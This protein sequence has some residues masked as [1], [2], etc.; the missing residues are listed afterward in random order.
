MR[1]TRAG[2]VGLLLLLAA[3]L[4]ASPLSAQSTSSTVKGVVVDKDGQPLP[5]VT[6]TLENPSLGVTGLGGV[7]NP[8]GEFRITPVPPGRGYT[9]RASLPAYQ[10][11]EFKDLEIPAGKTLVQNI[12]LRPAL[13]ERIRVQ[14]KEEV[15]NTETTTISTTI[16]SEFISGLPVLGRDY[17]D[18][19]TLAPGVTD[20]NDTGNPNIHGARDTSVVTLVDGVNT[21]DPFTGQYGQELNIESI[22]EIEVI[23][24]GASAEYGRA[25]GGFIRIV[26]K[27]GGNEFEGSFRFFLRT[28]ALD[29]DGAGIDPSELRGGLGET[30]GLRDLRFTDLQPFLALGGAFIK[31]KWWYYFTPQYDQLEQPVNA[32]TQSFVRRLTSLRALAKSTWQVTSNNKL[33]LSINY[34]DTSIYDNGLNSIIARESG[35]TS[36][37]GGPTITLT[38]TAILSP[39]LS[40]ETTLS[41]FDQNHRITPTTDPDTNGNG[42]LNVDKRP[43]LGGN[44]NGFIELRERDPGVDWDA[45]GRFDIFEDFNRNGSLDGCYTDPVTAEKICYPDPR[46]NFRGE[47][48]DRDGRLTLGF[49]CEG[50]DRED[51]D[52]DG[53][54]D[55]EIDLDGNGVADPDEDVGIPCN[56]PQACPQGYVP[57]TRGNGTLDSEDRD[58]NLILS[59]L[60]GS[61][62]S[63]FPFWNDRN[64][65]GVP[66]IGEFTSPI[67]PDRQYLFSFNTNRLTGPYRITDNDYRTRNT[68]REDVNWYIDDLFGSHDLKAGLVLENE[69]YDADLTRRPLWQVSTGVDLETGRIGGTIDAFLPTVENATNE[70]GS[71]NLALFFHDTYKPL[72]NLTIGLGLR[73][74]REEVR[75]DGFTFFEPAAERARFDLLG[76]LGGIESKEDDLNRD[77]I[78]TR[79]LASDPLYFSNNPVDPSRVASLNGD[80]LAIAPARLTRHNFQSAID[81]TNFGTIGLTDP[82]LLKNGFPR[83]PEEIAIT[84]NNLAPRLSVAWDPWAD[85]KTKFTSSWGRYYDKLF[86]RTVI[87]EAGP[88]FLNPYY[89]YDGDGVDFFGLPN[90]KVGR[91]ISSAP[92]SAN[93]VD[94]NLRTPFTDEF[95]F[96]FTRE[97]APEVSISFNYID[98][99]FRDLLQDVDMN[100]SPRRPTATLS[101]NTTL[102]GFC[103][104]FGITRVRPPGGGGGEAGKKGP[105]ER[106]P[107]RYPDLYINNPNFNQVLRVGNFNYQEYYAY[108]LQFVRRLSRKWQMDASYVFSKAQGQAEDFLSESGDDPAVAELK[109]GFLDYDQRHVA[110]FNAHVFLPGDWRLGTRLTWASGTPYSFVQRFR[111]S[112]NLDFPQTRRLYGTTDENSGLFIDENRNIHRNHA[113]Y[114]I[115]VRAEK[116]FV[117]GRI[118]ASAFLD[119]ENLLNQDRLRVFEIQDNFDFLQSVEERDFG[120]RFQVGITM[121]F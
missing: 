72:S 9:L 28:Q 53:R 80:L 47:D 89:G 77:G 115:S 36:S 68:F 88:D 65:N 69:G 13:T 51:I 4:L 23:T 8:Q 78:I 108:E 84:N 48:L 37:R 22:E 66:E 7:T 63:A 71:D 21:T 61:D 94:R 29:H 118:S 83:Q 15:V 121:N 1:S 44:R 62:S 27:S 109:A 45:D 57:G 12:T 103:D 120:R 39:S 25:Q 14:G 73:F 20:V 87:G 2:R 79:S 64:G 90:N 106:I 85:G 105:D 97:I 99:R 52:C 75:T 92:A 6:I 30:E 86:L 81:S 54:L 67:A 60:P 93:Q 38:D 102:S 42:I 10:K 26:T 96:G 17:Q 107:D 58:G 70:A 50:P 104:E 98:R 59:T 113:L 24:S 33:V 31:D 18:V 56:H 116:N 110:K 114:D 43:D 19:L 49:G 41:R 34:D 76:N 119:I 101:C 40:L 91:V 74:D 112:D 35:Y 5:G 82:T 32:G 100:H 16:T 55:A 11:I 111:S 46:N 95:T 117:I 3:T